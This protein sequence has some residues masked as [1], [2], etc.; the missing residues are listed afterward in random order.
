MRLQETRSIRLAMEKENF[1]LELLEAKPALVR[2]NSMVGSVPAS[3]AS[4]LY[5]IQGL[6]PHWKCT[7]WQIYD[8][9]YKKKNVAS[10]CKGVIQVLWPEVEILT[11][12]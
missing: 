5:P 9:Y 3:L 11:L 6:V 7:L 10:S 8:L 2:T 1:D 12:G 4:I